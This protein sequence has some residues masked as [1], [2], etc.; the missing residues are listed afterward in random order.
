MRLV[1]YV[2]MHGTGWKCINILVGKLKGKKL[3]G[4][5][6]CRYENNIKMDL[7]DTGVRVKTVLNY[8]V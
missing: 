7:K 4:I 6:G 8:R 2:S 1:G 3:L 5:P